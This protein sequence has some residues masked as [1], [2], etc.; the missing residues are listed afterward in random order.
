MANIFP[1]LLCSNVLELQDTINAL[2][3]YCNGYHLDVMDNHFVP[4][5]TWGH[6]FINA[7]AHASKHDTMWV[8]LM[9]TS[10]GSLIS[11][12]TIAQGSII[13]FHIETTKDPSR[14]INDIKLKG[15]KPSIAVNPSTPIE[16]VF[17]FLSLVNHILVMSVEPGFSGQKFLPTTLE[18]LDILNDYCSES[19]QECIIAVD[20]G[21]DQD[22]C[23]RLA[24][25][26]VTDFA[27]ASAIFN[28]KKS[29]VQALIEL[30]RLVNQN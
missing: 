2:D 17:P 5:L 15:W 9:V 29:S 27:I 1:S 14:L 20:G 3:P 28:Q 8:H 13:S 6:T 11:R 18:K 4:N 22:N 25:H 19:N 12:F 7:I 21:I 23:K 30:T 26:K 24:A 16:T 10:P